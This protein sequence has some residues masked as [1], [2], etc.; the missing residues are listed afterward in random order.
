M[1]AGQI[2]TER[3]A[4]RLWHGG[5]NFCFRIEQRLFE[6]RPYSPRNILIPFL[7]LPTMGFLIIFYTFP[8]T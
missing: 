8:A 5:C 7:V 4:R 1:D 3:S 6:P 2:F